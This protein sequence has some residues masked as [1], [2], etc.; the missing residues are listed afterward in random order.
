MKNIK[1]ILEKCFL[2]SFRSVYLQ[3]SL[4]KFLSFFILV[5]FSLFLISTTLHAQIIFGNTNYCPTDPPTTFTTI[6]TTYG[7]LAPGTGNCA[8]PSGSYDPNYYAAIISSDY[9]NGLACG[10]CA[11]AHDAA[12]GLSVT[13]MIVDNC[14]SCS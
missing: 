3:T 11:A 12:S 1:T 10:A 14:P 4:K 6:A 5:S 2:V 9:Q 13:V 7:P 8:F